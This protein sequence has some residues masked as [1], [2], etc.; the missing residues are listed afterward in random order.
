MSSVCKSSS[1]FPFLSFSKWPVMITSLCFGCLSLNLFTVNQSH[2]LSVSW[3]EGFYLDKSW[4]VC[5]HCPL[6]S[7]QPQLQTINLRL[8]FTELHWHYPPFFSSSSMLID[9][10]KSEWSES[11]AI[12]GWI[13]C[14]K[15]GGKRNNNQWSSE[16]VLMLLLETGD[17]LIRGGGKVVVNK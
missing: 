15:E 17:L 5:L 16:E 1:S 9:W 6:A 14:S 11:V 12:L 3:L 2:R 4:F 7:G 8:Y 13:F 10:F